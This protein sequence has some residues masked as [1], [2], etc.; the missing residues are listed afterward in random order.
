[1]KI[2]PGIAELVFPAFVVVWVHHEATAGICNPLRLTLHNAVAHEQRLRGHERMFRRRETRLVRRL[3]SGSPCAL[4]RQS[5]TVVSRQELDASG[6]LDE[7][8]KALLEFETEQG[9]LMLVILES[10]ECEWMY[11]SAIVPNMICK[12]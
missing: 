8:C 5:K 10:I 9:H 11:I 7:P 12:D 1:M 6:R 2:G 3:C 4:D